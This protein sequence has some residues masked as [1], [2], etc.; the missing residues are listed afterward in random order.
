MSA[1]APVALFLIGGVAGALALLGLRPV[2]AHPALL[3]RNYRDIEVPTAAGLVFFPA[4]LLVF[5]VALIYYNLFPVSIM[6]EAHPSLVPLDFAFRML[7]LVSGFCL[8]GLLDD[9]LG[10]RGDRGFAGHFSELF[11][12]RLT[13]G[14]LKA[15]GGFLL[16]AAVS[17]TAR[18]DFWM[19]LLNAA[20]I[21]LS[22]NLFN[23]LDL[24]PGR[25]IKVFLPAIA[26]VIA[27]NFTEPRDVMPYLL[28]VAAITLVLFPGDLSERFMLGDAGSNVMGAA[29]G[30]GFATGAG[31]WWKVGALVALIGLNVLS[32]AVSFSR[33]IE[34][35]RVLRWLDG[36][37][38]PERQGGNG[39][40]LGNPKG[41]GAR[42]ANNN[43]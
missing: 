40:Y 19:L 36:L 11:H 24:R 1:I 12:G 22:A 31:T 8:L 20:V 38:R 16:A 28:A 34:S 18:P 21:A 32:E 14:M 33:V 39:H 6:S 41:D 27:L 5:L 23:L 13:T 9:V 35:N 37:G 43:D 15:A 10:D 17:A 4:Y 2:L 3:R 42:E 26:G 30:L 29:V 25:A 7:L